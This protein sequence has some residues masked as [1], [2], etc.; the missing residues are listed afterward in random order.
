MS[1][2]HSNQRSYSASFTSLQN[3]WK[4]VESFKFKSL[5][6]NFVYFLSIK[7]KEGNG[8]FLTINFLFLE[9]KKER[10]S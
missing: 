2:L 1:T 5:E 8:L 6:K 9:K 3:L 4:F 7:I 10:E